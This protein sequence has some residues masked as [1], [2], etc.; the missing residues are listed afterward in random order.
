MPTL[1]D[2]SHIFT[3]SSGILVYKAGKH[4]E[5]SYWSTD[6]TEQSAIV[7]WLAF[8]SSWVQ[9]GVFTARAI[10]SFKGPCN[11]LGTNS[12]ASFLKE[13]KIRGI[14]SLGILD[15]ESAKRDWLALGR[16]TVAD[17]SVFVYVALA[18]MGDISLE[19]YLNVKSWKGRIRELPGFIPIE[20]LDDPLYR[21]K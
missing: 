20:G 2:G 16:P 21:R 12:T 4:P 18:P 17:I 3:D 11:G 8:A 13:A 19:P 1:V 14:K 7:D 6:L 5:S 15:G 10:L 9:Y